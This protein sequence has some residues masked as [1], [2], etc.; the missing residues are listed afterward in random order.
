M[1]QIVTA[2]AQYFPNEQSAA[3]CI[4]VTESG[5][6]SSLSLKFLVEELL[7]DLFPFTASTEE[8]SAILNLVSFLEDTPAFTCDAQGG[9]K[10]SERVETLLVTV[11]DVPL[12]TRLQEYPDSPAAFLSSW[13]LELLSIIPSKPAQ[14][15]QKTFTI[16]FLKPLRTRLEKNNTVQIYDQVISRNSLLSWKLNFCVLT[17][18]VLRHCFT[19]GIPLYLIY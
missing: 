5:L 2:E 13:Y 16:D 11:A 7:I 10:F 12:L 8:L 4:L 9:F 15:F 14:D 17:V 1:S 3:P 6:Y 19:N 18:P